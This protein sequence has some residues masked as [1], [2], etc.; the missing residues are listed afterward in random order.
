[1]SGPQ[2]TAGYSGKPLSQKIGLKPG[3]RLYVIAPPLHY[4]ELMG[5]AL[6]DADFQ[7]AERPEALG[8]TADIVHLFVADRAELDLKAR[9]VLSLVAEGGM[10]WVSWPKKSS[11]LFRDLTEDSLRR[12]LLPTGWVDVKV[13]AVDQDWSALKFL[14]R[15]R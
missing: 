4:A 5:A 11:R 13:A 9:S 1:M 2:P 6:R 7:T 15:K 14:R 8:G 12:S 10:L 3:H